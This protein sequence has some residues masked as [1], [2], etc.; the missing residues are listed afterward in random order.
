MMGEVIV[1]ETVPGEA[2]M[3]DIL[4]HAQARHLHMITNGRETRLCSFIPEGWKSHCV[5]IKKP[6]QVAA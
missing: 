1:L 3:L 5:S 6:P 4:Q 2:Q